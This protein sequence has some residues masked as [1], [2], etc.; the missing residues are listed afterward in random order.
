MKIYADLPSRRIGQIAADLLML[1]W[2]L[3]WA[4]VGK[5][6]HDTTLS[7]GEP[8][9]RLEI[10]RQINGVDVVSV[11]LAQGP[12]QVVVA[13]DQGSGLQDLQHAGLAGGLGVC[14]GGEGGDGDAGQQMTDH[15]ATP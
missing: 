5:A 6:V 7:L 8:G 13:V 11:L 9:R 2:I 4:R 10:G 3:L 12:G 14:G 1:G 15:D